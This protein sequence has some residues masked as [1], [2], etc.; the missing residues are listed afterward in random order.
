MCVCE[1][2]CLCMCECVL[3]CE[4]ICLCVCMSVSVCKSVCVCVCVRMYVWCGVCVSAFI[5]TC[6]CMCMSVRTTNTCRKYL[7]IEMGVV[8]KENNCKLG[9]S[10]HLLTHIIIDMYSIQLSISSINVISSKLDMAPYFLHMTLMHCT[11]VTAHRQPTPAHSP[12]PSLHSSIKS[13]AYRARL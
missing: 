10:S 3:Q 4:C 12:L 1:C 13:T 8:V 2:I 9:D 5:C 7:V 6:T 11:C